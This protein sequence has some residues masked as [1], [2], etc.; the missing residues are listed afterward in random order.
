MSISRRLASALLLSTSWTFF[1]LQPCADIVEIDVTGTLLPGS[2]DFTGVF[3]TPGGSN[4]AGQG[5]S[6]VWTW[7][8]QGCL[9]VPRF[10]VAA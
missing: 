4:L 3:G 1:P 8:T 5:F 2:I 6:V 7:N 9:T 10:L